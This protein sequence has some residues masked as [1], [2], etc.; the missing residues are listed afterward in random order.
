MDRHEG[1]NS[2]NEVVLRSG[3]EAVPY[4]IQSG[5][6][7]VSEEK[8]DVALELEIADVDND[9]SPP[10]VLIRLANLEL[11]ADSGTLHVRDHHDDWG[12]DDGKPHGF[13]YSGF[14]H[15]H[16]SA[17]V[18]IL[19]RDESELTAE[20]KIVTDDVRYY[21]ERATDNSIIGRCVLTRQSRDDMWHP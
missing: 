1:G 7:D 20:I 18:D 9:E 8:I 4:S 15:P 5:H 2:M 16:V 14:H 6:F 13:V 11:P 10:E 12:A 3:G 19:S 21:D 17:W